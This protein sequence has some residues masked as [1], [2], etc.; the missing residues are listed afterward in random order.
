MA[1]GSDV[2]LSQSDEVPAGT[3][4]S[5]WGTRF[6]LAYMENL[7]LPANGPP[8]FAV[9]ARAR[10]EAVV[11][12][13]APNTGFSESWTVGSGWV[14]LEL[15][16]AVLYPEG[17]DVV[18]IHG[19]EIASDRPIEVLGLHR[20]PFFS[21][22]TRVLPVGELGR[23]YRVLAAEDATGGNRSSFMVAATSDGT[24]VRIVPAADTTAL[25]PAGQ[26]I[27]VS[28]DAGE[29]YQIHSRGD[30]SGS[31]IEASDRIAVFG[32]G[33]DPAVDCE[34]T[35]HAWDQL[36]PIRRWGTDTRVVPLHGQ[37]GDVLLVVADRDGTEV[38]LDCGE[39]R[40]LDAGQVLRRPL[41]APT[42]VTASAPVGVGQLARGGACT[43]TGL[44]DANLVVTTPSALSRDGAVLF[45]DLT[46]PGGGDERRVGVSLVRDGPDGPVTDSGYLLA[47]ADPLEGRLRGVAF[48]VAAFDAY[49]WNLGHDC[50][51]C[52]L[53]L[54]EGV[55]CD[56]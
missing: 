9:V 36:L 7:A 8:S 44:G 47:G 39:V 1:C 54:A 30:L 12:V 53:A 14:R 50:E 27:E 28:L 23:R 5:T 6:W 41:T 11:T 13:S 43:A 4:A 29:T 3:D 20:R 15:P 33:A 51:D 46:F 19:L 34:A 21:E 31:L 22:A 26:P 2:S 18:G 55:D 45:D 38:R 37:G 10:T 56:E 42:R 49:T 52:V 16:E 25:F 40:Q 32:G 35:S 24:V 48:A 17:S